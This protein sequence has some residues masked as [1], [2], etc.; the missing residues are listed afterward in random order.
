MSQ[1]NDSKPNGFTKK[2]RDCNKQIYLH[3]GASGPWRAFEAAQDA[4][5]E[6][7]HRH[8]C[9]SSLRDAEILGIIAPPG[10]KIADLIPKLK[11]LIEDFA[12][13]VDQAEVRQ[14]EVE[15]NKVEAARIAAEGA[16]GP[17]QA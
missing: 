7:W 14:A 11:R 12:Q 8:R 6:E 2:C 5:P 4:D 15:A 17:A 3:R 13:L 1:N 16:V 10:T 9:D